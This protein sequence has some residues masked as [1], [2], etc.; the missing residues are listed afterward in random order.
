MYWDRFCVLCM[1]MATYRRLNR[2]KGKLCKRERI[3]R[4]HR[5]EFKDM[6]DA[7]PVFRYVFPVILLDL[8][9]TPILQVSDLTQSSGSG[10]ISRIVDVRAMH[11]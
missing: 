1:M 2:Q 4:R 9:L 3:D 11:L 6:G 7:S 5:A 8:D 10:V